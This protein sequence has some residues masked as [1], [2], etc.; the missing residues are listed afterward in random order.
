MAPPRPA[1][2]ADARRRRPKLVTRRPLLGGI[3]PALVAGLAGLRGTRAAA[4]DAP[5]APAQPAPAQTAAQPAKSIWRSYYLGT[6]VWAYADR[7][8]VDAG[9]TFNLMLS[10]GPDRAGAHGRIEIYRIGHHPGEPE[11]DRKLVWRSPSLAV[12]QQAVEITAAAIGAGWPAGLE[13]IATDG[14]RSGYYALDFI[15]DADGNRD[16]NVAYIVVTNKARQDAAKRGDILLLLSTNTWQA[17]NEWGGYSFYSSDFIGSA[18]QALTFDRPCPP[19]F[20]EYEYFLCLWLEELA[21]ERGW[22]VDYATNFDIHRDPAFSEN[23]RLLISGAHNEYWS[24]AEFKAMHRRIFTLGGNT[25]F[26]GADA[27]YWQVRYADVNQGSDPM[28]RGRQMICFKSADDPAFWRPS[29]A[30]EDAQ[31]TT[32][33]REDARWPET[34][35]T[36]AAYQ[37]WFGQDGNPMPVYPFYAVHTDLP[38]FAG[39]GY[40]TGDPIGDF[41]GYEWDNRDPDGDGMRLWS[42][43]ASHIPAIDPASIQ[44]LF[45]GKTVDVDGKPGLAEAVYFRSPAGGKVFTA[46]SIRWAWGLGKPGFVRA[47]FQLFNAQ[48]VADFLQPG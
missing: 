16:R 38:F 18:A 37:G 30:P 6:R 27:A 35:L 17:Y 43:T 25:M 4:A 46:G 19:E 44:V 3:L 36:G 39:T 24:L 33:F 34:M 42:A 2:G 1:G 26:L 21:A 40:R 12:S 45:Q 15:D 32:L 8:S 31:I 5:P 11:P 20:F 28:S 47:P 10:T 23:Y 22:T 14:W 48:L 13:S 29:P 7:H 41:V 9:E